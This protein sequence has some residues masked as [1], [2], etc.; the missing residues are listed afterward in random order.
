MKNNSL[1]KLLHIVSILSLIATALGYGLLYLTAFSQGIPVGMVA[2]V[3]ELGAGMAGLSTADAG[4]VIKAMLVANRSRFLIV[5][6]ISKLA[7]MYLAKRFPKAADA[8]A[9]SAAAPVVQENGAKQPCA[10][11]SPAPKPVAPQVPVRITGSHPSADA[12][13]EANLKRLLSIDGAGFALFVE[14][15][16]RVQDGVEVTGVLLGSLLAGAD[17]GS[18]SAKNGLD[19]NADRRKYKAVR[20]TRNGKQTSMLEVPVFNA[21]NPCRCT[22]LLNTF[23][24]PN[25]F[26][27]RIILG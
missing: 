19:C 9:P 18:V 14:R 17:C 20:I 7:E 1:R 22:V 2:W 3:G 8:N 23:E 16:R 6:I 27:G 25:A 10:A 12:V 11:K 4:S 5:F 26:A 13:I 15:A 24:Y 21:Q